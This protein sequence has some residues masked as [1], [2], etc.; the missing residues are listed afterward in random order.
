MNL[1]FILR[2]APLG[3]FKE[4]NY[5][6][7][8]MFLSEIWDVCVKLDQRQ[9]GQLGGLVMIHEREDTGLGT[10]AAAAPRLHGPEALN[11][12]KPSLRREKV[13]LEPGS[14]NKACWFQKGKGEGMCLCRLK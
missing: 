4:G 1:D 3:G 7:R 6:N 10:S 11:F 2:V 9:G 5:I 14:A 12:S 8:W 13:R